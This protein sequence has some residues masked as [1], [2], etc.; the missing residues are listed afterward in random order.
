[1]DRKRIFN[2]GIEGENARPNVGRSSKTPCSWLDAGGP[3]Y[4]PEAVPFFHGICWNGHLRAPK[5]LNFYKFFSST[6]H[7]ATRAHRVEV[8]LEGDYVRE[9]GDVNDQG[10]GATC[11]EA[12]Y[13]LRDAKLSRIGT[14]VPK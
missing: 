4:N 12:R 7:G 2:K 10:P 6:S 13:G 5:C 14:P 3:S 8:L 9:C 1:V 11:G